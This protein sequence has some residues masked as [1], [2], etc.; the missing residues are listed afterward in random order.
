MPIDADHLRTQV[1]ECAWEGV[2][3]T[4]LHHTFHT[5]ATTTGFALHASSTTAIA[6]IFVCTLLLQIWLELMISQIKYCN[7]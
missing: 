4:I 6:T 5:V 1:V 2:I 3:V 7:N